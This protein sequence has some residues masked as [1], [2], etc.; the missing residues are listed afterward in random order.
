MVVFVT[1]IETEWCTHAV[2]LAQ[3]ATECGQVNTELK[4]TASPSQ[5]SDHKPHQYLHRYFISK[6][7]YK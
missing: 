1:L 2:S 6:I 7:S 4:R 5:Q 3:V